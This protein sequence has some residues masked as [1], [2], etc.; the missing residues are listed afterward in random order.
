MKI[1]LMMTMKSMMTTME[2]MRRQTGYDQLYFPCST[3]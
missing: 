1:W 3:S 2:I